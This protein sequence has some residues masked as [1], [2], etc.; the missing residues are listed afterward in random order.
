MSVQRR[1]NTTQNVILQ[2][3]HCQVTTTDKHHLVTQDYRWV[4]HSLG[5]RYEG[6]TDYCPPCAVE[7]E[8]PGRRN[9]QRSALVNQAIADLMASKGVVVVKTQAVQSAAEPEQTPVAW[10]DDVGP[11]VLKTEPTEPRVGGGYLSDGTFVARAPIPVAPVVTVLLPATLPETLPE[12][13]WCGFVQ[14]G[15]AVNRTYRCANLADYRLQVEREDLVSCEAHV[16]A[17]LAGR[18]LLGLYRLTS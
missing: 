1:R 3:D 2:C 7:F 13:L 8:M 10:V 11:V 6:S 9:S 12:T 17:L 18:A 16:G 15:D 5:W 4:V 14:Q